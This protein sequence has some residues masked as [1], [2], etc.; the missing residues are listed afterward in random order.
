MPRDCTPADVVA[1]L[2]QPD[3]T[4]TE[5]GRVPVSKRTNVDHFSLAAMQ[6][7]VGG[8]IEVGDGGRWVANEDGAALGLPANAAA[9]QMAG[10]PLVGA[11]V[12]IS[13]RAA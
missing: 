1:T 4:C 12:F 13:R 3:G 9:S 5:V 6:W 2:V 10:R 11:V 8:Y 7:W